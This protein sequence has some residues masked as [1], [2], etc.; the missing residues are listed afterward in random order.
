[1]AGKFTRWDAADYLKTEEDM[2]LYLD[3]CLDEDPG[4]GSLIRAALNEVAR[5]KG[6]SRLA[7]RNFLHKTAIGLGAGVPCNIPSI[8]MSSSTSGQCTQMPS[9]INSQWSR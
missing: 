4:D 5:A 8:L 1:M 7:K 6:M 2:V 3:A 9:P